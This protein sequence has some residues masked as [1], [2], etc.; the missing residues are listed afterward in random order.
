MVALWI[1][2][3]TALAGDN[4]L[5]VRLLGPLS[6]A[7]A[8]LLLADAADRLLPGR[9][10]GLRAAALLNATLLFG[11]GGVMMT[12]DTPLLV[13]WMACLWALARLLAQRRLRGGGWRS[14]CS[15]AWR[16]TASTPPRCSGSALPSGCWSRRRCGSGC[17]GLR[18][19]SARCWV[20]RRSCRCCCGRRGTAG[21]ALPGRAAASATGTRSD[22]ARFLA[23]CGRADRPGHAADLRV[24][25]RRRGRGR[26]PGLAHARSGVDAAGRPD[27]AGGGAV[28]R[29]TRWAT[30]CRATGPPIIYPAAAHRR[31][32]GCPAPIW[33]ASDAGRPLRWAWR[34]R[35]W[36]ICRPAW[37]CCRCPPASTR[38]PAS[39]P[40]GTRS[41]IRS[42]RSQRRG[43][44]R[45]C[46]GG[47]VRRRP[48]NSPAPCRADVTVVSVDG[49]WS[50][51][52][53]AASG[54]LGRP[55][56][57]SWS[58]TRR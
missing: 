57:G 33:R 9:S 40:A 46:R 48:R 58:A 47:S 8:S 24:L 36:C 53:P 52:R 30:G 10:A 39:W 29:S 27:A 23:N 14:A 17:G 50:I 41:R 3:G 21:R 55:E 2:L 7:V 12:P 37:R 1:R 15:P 4:A 18:P 20:W 13:F 31:R 35:C 54:A 51:N 34:S 5:G 43:W 25:R 19:G 28:H 6:V 38:S 45:I 49:R 22:A 26:A 11:V 44:C 32:R 16:W 42:T 56:S